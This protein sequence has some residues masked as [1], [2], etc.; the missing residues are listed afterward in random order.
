MKI[1]IYR[2]KEHRTN[3]ILYWTAITI[4]ALLCFVTA[5]AGTLLKPLL[6]IP[7]AL[8][9]S[10][11]EDELNSAIIG[12]LC[13]FLLDISCGKLVG[14]NALILMFSCVITS[15][16]FTNLLRQKFFNI[17]V[18]STLFCFCQQY[19]DYFFYYSIWN[20]ENAEIVFDLY[21]IPCWII[22]SLCIFIVY[23]IIRFCK[24]TLEVKKTPAVQLRH[25]DED[26]DEFFF[27]E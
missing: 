2:T 6:L 10:M 24:K 1:N 5:C 7:L 14:F 23:P 19:L 12:V 20:K 17:V 8:C 13:G 11:Y 3:K 22:T 9:V 21:T 18:V 15:M 25:G 4:L 26:S 16:L 27:E